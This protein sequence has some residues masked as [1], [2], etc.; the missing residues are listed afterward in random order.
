MADNYQEQAGETSPQY[1]DVG[2]LD[3]FQSESQELYKQYPPAKLY[4]KES[5]LE[6][7]KQ[8]F[9]HGQLLPDRFV[10]RLDR[11]RSVISQVDAL[12][13]SVRKEMEKAYPGID[14]PPTNYYAINES[15]GNSLYAYVG[16]V[17]GTDFAAFGAGKKQVGARGGADGKVAPTYDEQRRSCLGLPVNT[18]DNIV[19]AMVTDLFRRADAVSYGL[20]D[21]ATQ[22]QVNA[23]ID[24]VY[25]SERLLDSASWRSTKMQRA[26]VRD[27]YSSFYEDCIG[28]YWNSR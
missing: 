8:L 1:A 15:K 25:E 22:D 9:E 26:S 20:P 10:L 14:P 4:T 21:T 27:A 13:A 23:R 19:D 12:V 24:Q 6:E 3:K 2:A 11:E 17:G 18:P 28:R 5:L 7:S 16:I